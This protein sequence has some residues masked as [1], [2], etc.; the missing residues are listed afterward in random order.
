MEPS[1][2]AV[3]STRNAVTEGFRREIASATSLGRIMRNRDERVIFVAPG[4]VRVSW[5]AGPGD[6][7]VSERECGAAWLGRPRGIHQTVISFRF[8]RV[9]GGPYV[10][11]SRMDPL[12]YGPF[13][14]RAPKNSVIFPSTQQPR[15]PEGRVFAIKMRKYCKARSINVL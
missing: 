12:F 5:M 6:I 15:P 4:I 11:K 3:P 2:L 8:C 9:A 1:T 13:V 10:M 14:R 7:D